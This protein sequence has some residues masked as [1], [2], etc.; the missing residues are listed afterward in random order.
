MDL[1]KTK[2]TLV[3]TEKA[4]KLEDRQ[5][6]RN[7]KRLEKCKTVTNRNNLSREYGINYWSSLLDLE[8]FDVV[9]FCA[10]DPMHNLFLRTSN[11]FSSSGTSKELLA[12]NK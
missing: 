5:H 1:G 8:Y 11:M 9:K 12:K 3:L 7:A 10:V 2:I 4:G 6:R